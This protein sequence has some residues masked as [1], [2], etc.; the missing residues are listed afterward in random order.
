M[1]ASRDWNF[2]LLV[3]FCLFLI[4]LG[5]GENSCV[6]KHN[7]MCDGKCSFSLRVKL[8][9]V[10]ISFGLS[11]ILIRR[12]A[13]C[14]FWSHTR[15]QALT[16]WLCLSVCPGRYFVCFSSLLA[17]GLWDPDVSIWQGPGRGSHL[18]FWQVCLRLNFDFLD[19]IFE[20]F[21]F[22]EVLN[23]GFFVYDGWGFFFLSN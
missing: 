7:R 15:L 22:L 4:R 16:D 5:P 3:C 18:Y 10:I 8:A 13:L 23:F 19:F 6:C 17:S 21:L 11:V 9:M 1:R 2:I 14:D 20:I 12:M